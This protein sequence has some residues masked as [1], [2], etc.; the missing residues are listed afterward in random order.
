MEQRFRGTSTHKVDAKGRVSIPAD[1]RRVLDACDPDR[2]AGTNPRMVLCFGDDRVPF[3]TIYTMQGAAE[4]G[5]MIEEMD[6]GDPH[7]EALEDYFYMNADT[8]SVDDSGRLILN[9]ALRERIGITDAAVF[10]GKGKTFRLH[11]PDAPSSATSRLKSVLHE[12]PEGVPVT[13]LLPK[14]RR[15]PE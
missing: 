9:A 14:K 11:S 13:S 15:T 3:Y 4:M 12:L 5:E 6:E 8:V 7:R 10:A 2:E 1:F